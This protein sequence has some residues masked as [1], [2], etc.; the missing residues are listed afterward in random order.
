MECLYMRIRQWITMGCLAW[1]M[2]ACC[3]PNHDATDCPR[4]EAV[5]CPDTV[6]KTEAK[7]DGSQNAKADAQDAKA[8]APVPEKQARPCPEGMRCTPDG[9]PLCVFAPEPDE[10]YCRDENGDWKLSP[11]RTISCV[12]ILNPHDKH[13]VCDDPSPSKE[14]LKIDIIPEQMDDGLYCSRTQSNIREPIGHGNYR[15]YDSVCMCGGHKVR[16]IS[17]DSQYNHESYKNAYACSR[18]VLT[19]QCGD[20]PLMHIDDPENMPFVCWHGKALKCLDENCKI[21]D[22]QANKDEICGPS[23]CLPSN[24]PFP[25]E[26]A[27]KEICLRDNGSCYNK[28]DKDGRLY[29]GQHPGNDEWLLTLLDA[30]GDVCIEGNCPCG[31]GVCGQWSYCEDDECHCGDM[32]GFPKKGDD[33]CT[34]FTRYYGPGRYTMTGK[35][36]PASSIQ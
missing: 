33:L 2:T 32:T 18:G 13:W 11:D 20:F 31:K 24:I 17:L 16:G 14:Y 4:C 1:A 12:P 22:L 8:D 30:P 5:P 21:G 19:L 27:G 26:A 23:R 25:Y 7:A 10:V 28:K 6:E 9:K 29:E 15:V 34:V 35:W 36:Y 3:P